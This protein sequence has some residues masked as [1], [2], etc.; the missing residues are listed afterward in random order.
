MGNACFSHCQRPHQHAGTTKEQGAFVSIGSSSTTASETGESYN[1]I[2]DGLSADDAAYHDEDLFYDSDAYVWF[3][4]FENFP[5]EGEASFSL[6]IPALKMVRTRLKDSFP[7]DRNFLNDDYIRSMACQAYA[8]DRNPRRA[9]ETTIEVLS[10]I[11]EW[12]DVQNVSE[13]PHLVSMAAASQAQLQRWKV[14]QSQLKRA[15]NLVKFLN[16]GSVYWHGMTKDG[17]PILWV[18]AHRFLLPAAKILLLVQEDENLVDEAQRMA[19]LLLADLGIQHGM[20]DGISNVCVICH[21]ESLSA[22]T[23]NDANKFAAAAA[24][25]ATASRSGPI[26]ELLTK[27]YPN[28]IH[29]VWITTPV[30]STSTMDEWIQMQSP[31]LPDELAESLIICDDDDD[32]EE[33][34]CQERLAEEVLLNG[35]EDLPAF[36][37]GPNQDHDHFYPD[38]SSREGSFLEFDFYGMKERLM[39][40]R[41]EYEERM[42]RE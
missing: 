3:D 30:S 28:R 7:N 19:L 38:S 40:Q 5:D 36:L 6:S 11:M 12:R 34:E 29:Q 24:A 13:L 15:Q 17:R 14:S 20:P 4:A 26:L 23:P 10:N 33:E 35:W 37:G 31:L 22:P 2:R 16:T 1:N 41:M 8:K 25:A 27:G 9:I 18:R 32:D 39:E 21:A 42:R